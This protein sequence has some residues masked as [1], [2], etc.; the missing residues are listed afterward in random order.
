[1]NLKRVIFAAATAGMLTV[2]GCAGNMPYNNFNRTGENFGGDVNR[3]FN[4]GYGGNRTRSYNWDLN[5]NINDNFRGRNYNRGGVYNRE[6]IYNDVYTTDRF[7]DDIWYNRSVPGP[8]VR[9]T[10]RTNR[11]GNPLR[12]FGRTGRRIANDTIRP[13]PGARLAERPVAGTRTARNRNTWDSS[14]VNRNTT[15]NYNSINRGITGNVNRGI[16]RDFN[17]VVTVTPTGVPRNFNAAV[18]NFNR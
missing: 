1:M 12:R 17:R 8:G 9:N 3:S 11:V 16:G 5:N 14:I 6:G 2:T 13:T 7:N 10:T 15:R 4:Y 18:G